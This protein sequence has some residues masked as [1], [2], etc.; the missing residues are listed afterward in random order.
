M[1]NK[2]FPKK[3]KFY[4]LLTDRK[5]SDKEYEHV[6][7]VWKKL[8]MKTILKLI[9]NIPKNYENYLMTIL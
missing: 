3:E 7:K 9:L 1:F 5:A 6:I 8:K 2:E 4:S